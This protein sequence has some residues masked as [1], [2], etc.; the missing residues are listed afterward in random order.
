MNAIKTTSIAALVVIV[1]LMGCAGQASYQKVPEDQQAALFRDL[2]E[3]HAA[4]RVHQCLGLILFEPKSDHKSIEL[5]GE[6]C[7]EVDPRTTSLTTGTQQ[8]RTFRSLVGTDSQ[9]Y[10][11]AYWNYRLVHVGAREVD[12]NIMR[13]WS[14]RAD[15][16]G[17]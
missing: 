10:A 16:G 2:Q 15:N 3:N 1:G 7:R 6:R 13:I 5:V 17:P 11:Y 8:P 12:G 9:P 14:S 4:Y